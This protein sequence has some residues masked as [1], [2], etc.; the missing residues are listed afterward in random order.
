MNELEPTID[1]TQ[2]TLDQGAMICP[3]CGRSL[4]DGVYEVC[5]GVTERASL[6][7]TDWGW[8]TGWSEADCEGDAWFECGGCEHRVPEPCEG[9]I[10]A[11]I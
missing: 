3:N 7:L 10:R 6:R 4:A 2:E 5:T 8:E 11:R 9:W 1:K